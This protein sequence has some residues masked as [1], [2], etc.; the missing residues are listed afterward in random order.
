MCNLWSLPGFPHKGWTCVSMDD[1]EDASGTCEACGMSI[2][3]V[4]EM[5]H[6]DWDGTIEVGCVCAGKLEENCEGARERERRLVN[7]TNRRENWLR[8]CWR[9]S[10]KGN[11][12]LKV[13]G[14]IVGVA[15][16][17]FRPEQWRYWIK[18][19]RDEFIGN[20]ERYESM[21]SAQ[22][23]LFDQLAVILRW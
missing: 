7:C 22:L 8:R 10:E 23:A 15:P 20:S 1:L 12:Y 19:P 13:E 5:Q 16:D 18:S 14:Y 9:I 17:K 3:Y 2:R 4:H 6:D 21:E 11:P